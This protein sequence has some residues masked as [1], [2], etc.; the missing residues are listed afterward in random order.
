MPPLLFL[1]GAS[2]RADFWA[3]L[4]GRL[5]DLGEITRLTWPGFA[6]APPDPSLG[7]LDDLFDWLVDR[8]PPGRSHVVAQSMGGV[9]ALRLALDRPERVARLVLCA[10]SGGLDVA[11]LGAA[12]W[13]PEYR[14]SVP[15]V[16]SWFLT[17][18]TDLSA[19][20]GEVRAR[21]LLLWSDADPISPLA[22]GRALLARLPD[23]RLAVL[24]GGDH[25]FAE[26]RVAEVAEVV[27][28]FLEAG[29]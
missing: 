11:S 22:V 1:P 5:A 28:G 25:L 24:P 14:A 3:P 29:S 7:S 8:L 13:R 26:R 2:G 10:T 23:A 16:P 6:G 4:A 20:L 9:L 21:T 12:D 27:R 19:R 18:R 17:D 15:G